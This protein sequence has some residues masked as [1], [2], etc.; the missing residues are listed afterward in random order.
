MGKNNKHRTHVSRHM[1]AQ[2][3]EDYQKKFISKKS[4]PSV[5]FN[6]DSY[7][8][9]TTLSDLDSS[10]DSN[11]PNLRK[12]VDQNGR[13]KSIA[14]LPSKLK[15]WFF[16]SSKNLLGN[17]EDTEDMNVSDSNKIFSPRSRN[18]KKLKKSHEK[19]METPEVEDD[20]LVDKLNV[21]QSKE[22]D[23]GD[24]T[25]NEIFD[26]NKKE[27]QYYRDNS[28]GGMVL[29]V[30]DGTMPTFIK[31]VSTEQLKKTHTMPYDN[32][33]RVST[34]SQQDDSGSIGFTEMG[35]NIDA[36][37]LSITE[38]GA[39]TDNGDIYSMIDEDNT[40]EDNTEDGINELTAQFPELS[41]TMGDSENI[42]E[43]KNETP[44]LLANELTDFINQ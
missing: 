7:T 32:I 16:K 22:E 28:S 44:E 4:A 6:P 5:L 37:Q 13:R 18:K 11:T 33:L 15:G 26:K 42:L 36:L 40:Y 34:S 43:Y 23:I 8:T 31:N 1:S 30:P 39:V 2:N 3:K 21:E 27:I 9:T 25:P 35:D 12:G 19:Q 29:F 10:I 14:S 24:F 38:T 20:N 41:F 17:V